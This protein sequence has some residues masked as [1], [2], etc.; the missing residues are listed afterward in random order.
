MYF[1]PSFSIFFQIECFQIV[2]LH[3]FCRI[4]WITLKSNHFWAQN[5]QSLFSI[6]CFLSFGFDLVLTKET[7][8]FF[9]WWFLVEWQLHFI[10]LSFYNVLL[11]KLSDAQI[12]PNQNAF[13]NKDNLHLKSSFS[14]IFIFI[15]ISLTPLKHT[16]TY[17]FSGFVLFSRPGS[18]LHHQ[19][20]C[21]QVSRVWS[22]PVEEKISQRLD[23][24]DATFYRHGLLRPHHA[25]SGTR[26]TAIGVTV[27]PVNK[28][29]CS[30]IL[31]KLLWEKDN[32][33]K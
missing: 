2:I 5:V 26:R 21:F 28:L 24:T 33:V 7:R 15:N 18:L 8:S 16:N 32:L 12:L 29:Q 30:Q 10:R 6:P 25:A 23:A 31:W 3:S 11:W 14:Y 9:M 22:S 19:L 4:S 1:F 27:G 13:R 17:L 20:F